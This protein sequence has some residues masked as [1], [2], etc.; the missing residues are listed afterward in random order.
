MEIVGQDR[1]NMAVIAI[2]QARRFR[3]ASPWVFRKGITIEA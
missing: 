2:E 1:V 3:I